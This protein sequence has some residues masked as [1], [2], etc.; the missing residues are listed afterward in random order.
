MHK[1]RKILLTGSTGFLGRH[2]VPILIERYGKENVI[3]FSSKDYD[4]MNPIQV[5]EMFEKTKPQVV[6]H[7]AAYSG[8][9]GANR[10]FPADFY[11]R[12]TLLTALTFDACS[13]FNV[14]K[15]VYPMGGC[16]Y[17]AN[18]KSPINES[19]LFCGYPQ[20]ESAGY[21]TA[22]MMGVVA[23]KSYKTQYGLNSTV[24]IPGN[25]YGEFDNFNPRDSHVIA[26]MIRR[27]YEAKL[28]ND[29]KVIMWGTG[30]PE[31]DFVYAGD[32]AAMIPYFIDNFNEIG[33][34]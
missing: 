7:L 34:K 25:M 26:A 28:K 1:L 13:R 27:Y 18:A 15:V 17:P 8:G 3:C 32:V 6:V 31:R 4:L 11:Y 33:Q 16:S 9:I 21:S 19:Q 20:E 29:K 23:A 22:K 12:N 14:E 30:S 2:T 24:I 5:N 10:T